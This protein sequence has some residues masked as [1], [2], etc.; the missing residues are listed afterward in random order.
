[1]SS[2]TL[3]TA[4]G[5]DVLRKADSGGCF[6]CE[7]PGVDQPRV[8]AFEVSPAGPMFGPKLMRAASAVAAAEDALLAEE[9]LTGEAFR[10]GGGETEGA[11]RAYRFRAAALELAAEGAD[12]TL[13]FELPK[14]SYATVLL[15]E[16]MKDYIR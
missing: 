4:L 10:R 6:L 15:R 7:D 2:G 3:G 1:M 16:L 5:G 13:T 9:G 8:D 12:C 14:G 11:R